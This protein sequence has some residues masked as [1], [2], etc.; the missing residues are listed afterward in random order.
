MRG[1]NIQC[2]IE[3]VREKGVDSDLELYD[4]I[5]KLSGE[6]IYRLSQALGWSSG[7]TYASVRRLERAGMIHIEKKEQK[8]RSVLVVRPK[9]WMEYLTPEELEEFKRIE[10]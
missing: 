3:A 2:A 10:I 9:G 1:R 8:G 7:K 4:M 6:N 5:E